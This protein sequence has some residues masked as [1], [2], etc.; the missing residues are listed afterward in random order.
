MDCRRSQRPDYTKTVGALIAEGAA[1]RANCK[2]CG[3][4]RDIDLQAIADRRGLDFDLWDKYTPC[5]LTPGCPGRN[6][7][8]YYGGGMFKNMYE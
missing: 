6:H 5:R 4:F 1:V 3:Q 7:F 8:S 2:T